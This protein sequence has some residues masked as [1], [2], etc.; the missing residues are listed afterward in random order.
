MTRC[1]AILCA[2]FTVI[3]GLAPA[4]AAAPAQTITRAG[5][6]ALIVE[7]REETRDR[8]QWYD[9]HMPPIALFKDVDQKLWYGPYMETAF[10]EGIVTGN[11]DRRFRPAAALTIEEALVLV[12][13]LRERMDPPPPPVLFAPNAQ[14]DWTLRAVQ[15]AAS[16]DLAI[17]FPLRAGTPV[18]RSQFIALL[19]SAGVREPQ[20][21]TLSIDPKR[22]VTPPPAPVIAARP[23]QPIRTQP[24]RV[25]QP[26]QQPTPVLP[27]RPTPPGGTEHASGKTFA[28]SMPTLGV[29]DLTITHPTNPTTSQGLLA[30]LQAGVGHLFSYPGKGGNILIYGHSSSFPWDVSDYTKIFRQINKLQIGDK[31]YVTHDG[32]LYVYQVTRHQ[33]VSAKDTSAYQ[34]NAGEQLILYTCWPPDSISQRYLVIAKPLE[35]IALK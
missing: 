28:I 7:S 8:V 5:A 30:P 29:S 20:L 10:E 23:L 2:V 3:P 35:Q 12:S 18:T 25:A 22:G 11:P 17:P 32:T 33:T 34:A 19:A 15:V 31:V 27:T 26:V 4:I 24:V 9:R 6:V 13:R 14:T 16:Y 1:I 21:L